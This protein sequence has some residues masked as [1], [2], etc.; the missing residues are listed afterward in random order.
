MNDNIGNLIVVSIG[1]VVCKPV[2]VFFFETSFGIAL[3][4]QN[5][6]FPFRLTPLSPFNQHLL[7]ERA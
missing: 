2:P 7:H 4:L 6:P 1:L 3:R 5:A